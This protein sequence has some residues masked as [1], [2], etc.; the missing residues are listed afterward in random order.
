MNYVIRVGIAD[1]RDIILVSARLFTTFGAGL[2]P[3]DEFSWLATRNT[4]KGLGSRLQRASSI[5]HRPTTSVVLGAHRLYPGLIN[6]NSYRSLQECYRQHKP[7]PPSETQQ[8]SSTPQRGPRS[9]LTL[10]P[11]SRN[12]QGCLANPDLTAACS[13]NN[14]GFINSDRS[15]ADSDYVN[16]PRDTK[17]WSRF[18]GSNWQKD[19]SREKRQ[20]DFFKPI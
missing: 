7:L 16:N 17:N 6:L 4:K 5:G 14:F 20:L 10:F 19:I 3:Y 2:L 18:S 1:R 8:D 13:A 9:I 12:G 11:I 15:S